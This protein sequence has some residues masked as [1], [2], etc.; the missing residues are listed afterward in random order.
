MYRVEGVSKGVLSVIDTY[1]F[2]HLVKMSYLLGVGV[3]V[4]RRFES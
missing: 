4:P 3:C 2:Y 1:T